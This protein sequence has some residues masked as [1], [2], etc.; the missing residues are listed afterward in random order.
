MADAG[1]EAA[2]K[3]YFGH[4]RFRRGQREL[5]EGLLAR[6]VRRDAH[7]RRQERL[8]PAA[9]H[10]AAGDGAG[11]LAP[12]LPDEGPGRGPARGGRARGLYQQLALP[13]RDPRDLLAH[14]GGRL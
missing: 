5:A 11:D 14:E 1:I 13:G 2:L 4:S 9:G 7:G 8:L 10:P 3:R 6:R 12:H